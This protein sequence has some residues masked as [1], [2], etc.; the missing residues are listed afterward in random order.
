MLIILIAS[1]PKS[2]LTGTLTIE[3][4]DRESAVRSRPNAWRPL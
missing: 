1:S 3:R 4:R 2:S